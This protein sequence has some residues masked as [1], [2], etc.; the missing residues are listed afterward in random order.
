MN[1]NSEED[2]DDNDRIE[3]LLKLSESLLAE[4]W[5]SDEDNVWDNI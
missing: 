2:F 1:E 3:D 4:D 5:N